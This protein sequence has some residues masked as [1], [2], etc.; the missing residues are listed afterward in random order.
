MIKTTPLTEP[1]S[2]RQA[3][4]EELTLLAIERDDFI[5]LDAD[6][7]GGTFIK[8]FWKISLIGIL[9]L[10]LLSKTCSQLPL[11]FLQLVQYLL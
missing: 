4:A 2:M 1:Q 8:L 3:Y 6:T 5:I 9:H 10:E 7:L 11:A